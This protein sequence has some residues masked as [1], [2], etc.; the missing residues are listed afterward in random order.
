MLETM[1]V[2]DILGVLCVILYNA[3][4]YSNNQSHPTVTEVKQV[5]E[6]SERMIT[7]F[8]HFKI[9]SKLIIV[10]IVKKGIKNC[11]KIKQNKKL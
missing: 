1:E 9:N 7:T 11:D 10:C 3:N 6:L 8:G 4:T 2:N 5:T